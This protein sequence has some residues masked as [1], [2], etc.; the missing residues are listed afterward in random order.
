LKLQTNFN[1]ARPGEKLEHVY[2]PESG[3]GTVMA[4]ATDGRST[5]AGMFGREGFVPS[6]TI[7]GDDVVP[8]F[9]EVNVP[10]SV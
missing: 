8:Y 7:I 1:I 2:F 4:V 6:S 10:G 3:I 9:I 5:E